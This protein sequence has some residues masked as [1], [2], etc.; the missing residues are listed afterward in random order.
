MNSFKTPNWA[1]AL[2]L[3]AMPW[4][5]FAQV[6]TCPPTCPAP[7]QPGGPPPLNQAGGP[8][9]GAPP[10]TPPGT[11]PG[12]IPGMTPGKAQGG[13]SPVAGGPGAGNRGRG[14]KR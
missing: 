12:A 6:S 9:P 10:G 1:A 5:A 11:A 4:I 3:S 7:G 14:G 8:P 13:P 2:V